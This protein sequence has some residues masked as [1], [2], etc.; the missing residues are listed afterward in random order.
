[1]RGLGDETNRGVVD[2]IESTATVD[3]ADTEILHEFGK[4]VGL[5]IRIARTRK[6]F[7]LS[8]SK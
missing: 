2:S 8:D 4:K 5:R 7:E 3:G 1:V 6:R